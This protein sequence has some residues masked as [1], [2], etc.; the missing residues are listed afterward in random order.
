MA[1]TAAI[2]VGA[3]STTTAVSKLIKSNFNYCPRALF[4]NANAPFPAFSHF[5]ILYIPHF[6]YAVPADDLIWPTAI[7][8][9]YMHFICAESRLH[10][11]ITIKFYAPHMSTAHQMQRAFRANECTP[12]GRTPAI[13]CQS[14]TTIGR[15]KIIES[16]TK[17][18][19]G[20]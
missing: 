7:S 11:S 9:D 6:P 17:S 5:P 14:T 3:T 13:R 2:T 20:N 8:L 1:D 12:Y 10:L 16:P 19:Y 4:A 15:K 18:N